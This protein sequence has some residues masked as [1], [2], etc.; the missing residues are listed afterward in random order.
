[1]NNFFYKKNILFRDK[2]VTRGHIFPGLGDLLPKKLPP[3]LPNG[4]DDIFSPS[5]Q[6][7]ASHTASI[8]STKTVKESMSPVGFEKTTSLN[9]KVKHS[10]P[11]S[12]SKLKASVFQ[13]YKILERITMINPV[14]I[15]DDDEDNDENDEN[16]E[17][18]FNYTDDDDDDRSE[19]SSEEKDIRI[20]L[21]SKPFIIPFDTKNCI[22]EVCVETFEHDSVY[23]RAISTTDSSKVYSEISLS[24]EAVQQI[25]NNTEFSITDLYLITGNED[26]QDL[27]IQMINLFIKHDTQKVGYLTIDQYQELLTNIN[28]GIP[29]SEMRHVFNQLDEN[30]DNSLQLEEFIPLAVDLIELFRARHKA[31][32][33][34]LDQDIII[35]NHIK[36]SISKSEVKRVTE[37][38]ITAFEE[39]DLNNNGIINTA[40][41]SKTLLNMDDDLH[42]L[43]HDEILFLCKLIPRDRFDMCT[44]SYQMIFDLMMDIRFNRLKNK[45]IESHCSELELE[46]LK[47]C[48]SEE[49]KLLIF[50]GSLGSLIPSKNK[51][52]LSKNELIYSGYISIRSLMS[53]FANSKLVNISRLQISVILAEQSV[54]DGMVSYYRCV[55]LIL[56]TIEMLCD[57]LAIR[58]RAELIELSNLSSEHLLQLQETKQYDLFRRHLS[59]LFRCCD[60]GQDKLLHLVEFEL[61]LDA[62]EF[63][64]EKFESASLFVLATQDK[65]EVKK[66]SFITFTQFYDCINQ[67]LS[68]LILEKHIR[69]LIEM[70]HPMDISSKTNKKMNT[71]NS[72]YS[73]ITSDPMK[74]G[75]IFHLGLLF[76][77]WDK[78]KIGFISIIDLQEIFKKLGV[79]VLQH[80]MDIIISLSEMN[81]DL[82]SYRE[83]LPFCAEFLQV[84]I[85]FID[86]SL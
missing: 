25:V 21:T 15:I 40:D 46:I 55:P 65:K 67:H 43:S 85:V 61:F 60:V 54:I 3:L 71:G 64:L 76:K 39:I 42:G 70:I 2:N 58:Q 56:K 32:E 18:V 82:L 48:K 77:F 31:T 29:S 37:M 50:S 36:S 35:D 34:L 19:S 86:F 23:L 5:T 26:I 17:M 16:D 62:L 6:S 4:D 53:I 59:T 49:E 11:N 84:C 13:N 10:S 30:R 27:R 14:G 73:L 63:R 1:M 41:I 78:T 83:F 79:I 7:Y 44:Y 9:S 69:I 12:S 22:V 8:K 47:I 45:L 20:V 52:K 38:C 57:P 80:V 68:S 66:A 33:I 28:L 51:S 72:R 75:M 81:D 24:I 74:D